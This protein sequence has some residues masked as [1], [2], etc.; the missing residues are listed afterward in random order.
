MDFF[1]KYGTCIFI[2]Q[3]VGG[4]GAP[5]PPH[6]SRV[7]CISNTIKFTHLKCTQFNVFSIPIVVHLSPQP[8][9]KTFQYPSQETQYFLPV[10][11]H[12]PVLTAQAIT[13]LSVSRN[14]T[15]LG[16][17][18]KWNHTVFVLSLSMMSSRFIHVVA[19]VRISFL[20]KSE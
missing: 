18:C 8:N 7:N 20:F 9:F 1:N 17:S 2:L 16:T 11:P 14:L 6:C 19:C 10:I 5:N 13:V 15:A 3:V 12:Y 4:I